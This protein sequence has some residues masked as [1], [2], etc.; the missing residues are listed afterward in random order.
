MWNLWI[1]KLFELSF[2]HE[3]APNSWENS[4]RS[5]TNCLKLPAVFFVCVCNVDGFLSASDGFMQLHIAFLILFKQSSLFFDFGFIKIFENKMIVFEGV[6]EFLV[7]K[8]M[9]IWFICIVEPSDIRIIKE[10]L[11]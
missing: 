1:Y 7:I 9:F 10:R 5:G 8:A 2:G 6:N 11:R 4:I 3:I